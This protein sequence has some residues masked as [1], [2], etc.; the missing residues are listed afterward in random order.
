MAVTVKIGSDAIEQDQLEQQEEKK[1]QHE[2]RSIGLD[3][4]KTLDGN[5]VVGDLAVFDFGWNVAD[6]NIIAFSSV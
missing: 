3:M 5:V 2:P 1:P 4:R 6:C